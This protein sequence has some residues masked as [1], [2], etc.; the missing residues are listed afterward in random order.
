MRVTRFF[1]SFLFISTIFAVLFYGCKKDEITTDAAA[2][3]NF[4][5]DSIA[6]DTVFSTV[7][8]ITKQLKVYNRNDKALKFD[9]VVKNGNSS[10]FR[11]NVD[12]IP[13]T[14]INDVEIA[15]DDSTF[16]FIKVTVDPNDEDSPFVVSDQLL[17]NI[18]GNEQDV[19]LVAWGQNAY[20]IIADTHV[21]GLPPY[22]IVAHE[23]SDTTWDS[24][25][26][27]LIYGYAVVDSNAIL[28]IEDSAR[29]HFHNN[30]G[31]WVYKGGSLKVNGTRERPVTFQGSRLD[32]AYRDVPGQWDRIW[33]NEGAV[34]NEI[35]YAII[36]NGFIGLQAE[37][38]QET[39]GNELIIKNTIIENMTGIGLFTRLYNV[40]A[41]NLLID[42]C[43]NYGLAL[44]IGGNYD[45]R[46]STFANYWTNS[47]RQTPNLFFNNFYFDQNETA[48]A[49]D[50][51]AYFGNCI[52]YGRND[53]EFDF[54][55]DDGAAFHYAFDHCL[56]KT[57]KEINDPQHY[58]EC[59]KNEDPLFVDPSIFDF[60]IDTL[61]PA[62]DR[63]KMEIALE[64]PEDILG[65]SRL[66]SP[67]LGAYE[68][69]P[70]R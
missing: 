59:F 61:S 14:S 51:D 33:I 52:I 64:I 25:K 5:S 70:G 40:T 38:L 20:Y 4:S 65:N 46:Q 34:N 45:F 54:E 55:K 43:G 1:V 13:G 39:M 26:P 30:A 69:V 68:F 57:E 41:E 16:I 24:R 29:I 19:D 63:G 21:E 44:T 47:V 32:F 35:N 49:F 53:E 17:F 2:K 23:F 8:S 10:N 15:P 7:G 9:V 48:H 66:E 27:Y 62:I 37:T 67:D 56:L 12:G 50:F 36:R 18:N 31:L 22:K 58:I 60:A 3:L 42:N 28:R 11:I 6:F